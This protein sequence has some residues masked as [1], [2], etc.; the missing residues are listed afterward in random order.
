MQDTRIGNCMALTTLGNYGIECYVYYGFPSHLVMFIYSDYI[1]NSGMMSA[2][3][4]SST[5]SKL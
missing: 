1:L 3:I 2:D 5:L 4:F